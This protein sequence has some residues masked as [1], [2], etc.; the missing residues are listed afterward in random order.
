MILVFTVIIF[1]LQFK[2]V[3][4][5]AAKKAAGYLSKELNT[6]I[7]IKSLYIKPFK[8]IVLEDLLVLDLDKDTL[9]NTPKFL[10][11]I[12]Q[13]SLKKRILDV[14]TVQINNGNIYLKTNKD[15]TSNLDFIINYFDSGSPKKPKKTKDPFKIE[16]ERVILNNLNFKYKN[17]KFQDT[18]KSGVNFEDLELTNLNG[19]FEGL[20]T[21]DHLVKTQIKNLGFREKS[22]FILRN[23][24]AAT[25]IDSNAIELKNLTLET[26]KSKLGD[27]VKL[28]FNSYKDFKDY[29]HKVRMKV[30]FKSS[31]LASS[32]IA[33][34]ASDL[35]KMKLDIDIDGAVS[36]TVDDIKARKISIKVGKATYIKGDLA[37][38][39]LP[40]ISETFIDMKIEMAGTNKQDLDE[41]LG[42]STGS[43]IK[44]IPDIV[45]KFGDVNFNGNFTGFQN[46]F[47]AYGEFKTKLGR[48]VSD[49]NMKID[50]NGVPSYTGNVKTFDF[51]IGS[52]IDEPLLNRITSTLNIKG[53]GIELNSL[54]E[55]LE[56]NVNYL[57][58][59]GYRYTNVK[60]DGIFEKKNFNGN[61]DINDPN[62]KLNFTGGVNLNPE[63]PVF[64]FKANV[65]GAKLKTL[66]VYKDSL[67]VDADLSA[68]FS[69]KNL[70]NIQGDF[71]ISKIKLTNLRGSYTV[72]SVQL[73]ATGIGID[74][75]LNIKSDI[76]DA[77][78]TGQYDLN[79]I[80]NYYQAIAKTYVPSI[81]VKNAQ[82]NTQIFQFNLRVKKFEPIAELIDPSLSIPEQAILIGNFDS[83][84]NTATLNGFIKKLK[85]DNI[86][87][88]DIII[89]ESTTPTELQAVITSGQILLNDSLFLKDLNI[90]NIIRNDS[91]ALN[92][93]LSN[94]DENN[95]LDLNGLV[96]FGDIYNISI[97]PSIV[98]INNEEWK[99]QDKVQINFKEG[100]T[101]ISNFELSNGPQMLTLNGILS[102]DKSD[103][104]KVGFKNFN[105]L[106]ANPFTR[107]FGVI[108]AGNLNGNTSIYGVFKSPKISDNITID[109][110]V[111]NNNLIGNLRDTSSYNGELKHIN[112]YTKVENFGKESL[113]ATGL[114]DLATKQL[115]VDIDLDRSK[116][117]IIEPFVNKLVSNLKGELSADL[118]V[119]GPFEKPNIDGSISF[120]KGQLTVNYLKTPI[121]LNDKLI[122]E[123][124]IIKLDGVRLVDP[125]GHYAIAN[126]LVDLNNINDPY[127]DAELEADNFMALNTTS[128]DNSIYF[129][130]AYATGRFTFRGP[131]SAMDIDIN[132]KT[133]KGTVFNLP[134]NSSETVSE[135]DF[136]RFVSKDSLQNVKKQNFEGL[137][138]N[139]KLLIDP[140]T[141]ANIY[142]V[143]GNLSGKGN[144]EL[145]LNINSLGDFEMKGDYIIESG[146]FDFTAQEVINKRF[147]IRQ[148]GTIR[149]TGD[150]TGAQINLKA[151]YALRANLTDLYTAAN[152]EA[153]TNAN[154]S[155]LTEVEM[156]LSG[157][158]LQPDIK[159]DIF[160]PANPAVKE[161][162]QVYFS[163][164]Q[165]R[166]VQAVSLIVRRSFAPGTG[167]EAIGKQLTSGIENTAQELFFNQFNNILSSLN[168]NFVDINVRSFSE[169]NATFNFFN[170]R[171]V[172]NAGIVD[173][174]TTNSFTPL[175]LNSK[176]IGREVEIL[177]L[178][179]KDGTL[180]GKL[181]NK[182]PTQQNIFANPGIDQNAN[183]TSFGIIYTQQFD[184]FKEF[185][186]KISGKYKKDQRRKLTDP[187]VPRLVPTISPTELKKQKPK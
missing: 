5:Y 96:E 184:N 139:F 90:S 148:G 131:T 97:L 130:K 58:F 186:D 135:K 110:L 124:S 164:Q 43:K 37:L 78:I 126:G 101:E 168:L 182:P 163:D 102:A 138:L 179:K 121:T 181:A 170:D 6:T 67:M 65:R 187:I 47:V 33:F 127:I 173:N 174:R 84:N 59:N 28:S 95:Q 35:S 167:K 52:L 112:I 8:S 119:T 24:T 80:A 152:R 22:G 109:S 50:K 7:S 150:P 99:I 115:D 21:K 79:T 161:E 44:V 48:L 45:S 137:T 53:R 159:L 82:H 75:N 125:D 142:T 61:L 92:V 29:I 12:N 73:K 149:W 91:L 30:N 11:D 145:E 60:V 93:K 36:G 134:L 117:A 158:L 133:E 57:D 107:N 106:T 62:V 72:D 4:T 64:N 118:K 83:R 81:K 68:N 185:L 120:D 70:N 157:S 55:S 76:L 89:D 141:T 132:A 175:D 85:Y 136:I 114:V 144:A 69:G 71:L 154:A 160:F 98:K 129:G 155:L 32:D 63:L 66:Q 15:N 19:I 74:R 38:K 166:E 26:N 108:L 51:D 20:D 56:G 2:S 14:N 128:R 156:G 153:T 146:N 46:D 77:S 9:L 27:Y 169:A 104:L 140:N 40:I 17:L 87:A 180:V 54:Y 1:S 162:F 178:I 103:L 42:N 10:V 16:F 143:I 147:T 41:I 86:T 25:T 116:L 171:I 49:V 177:G 13:F 31:Y 39:G 18:I 100:K 172:I 151:I 23:L 123:N 113:S 111:L 165:N 183:V 88:N 105:L 3:Q 34:F 176:A 122:V 94:I